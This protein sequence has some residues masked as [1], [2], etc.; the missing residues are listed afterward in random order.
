MDRTNVHLYSMISHASIYSNHQ[1]L[2]NIE[3]T[4]QNE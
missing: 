1:L 4:A 3:Y 2:V